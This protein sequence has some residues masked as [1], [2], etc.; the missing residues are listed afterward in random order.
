MQHMVLCDTMLHAQQSS[1]VI[2]LRQI[3]KEENSDVREERG[4]NLFLC[5]STSFPIFQ[6][7]RS[8]INPIDIAALLCNIWCHEVVVGNH[9]A[10]SEHRRHD[11]FSK[12]LTGRLP[13][14]WHG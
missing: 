8:R 4:A 10:H 14:S 13:P 7:A 12:N 6:G 9:A 3:F 2:P 11:P 5:R 1:V